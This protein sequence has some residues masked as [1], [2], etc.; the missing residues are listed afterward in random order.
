M[1][2]NIAIQTSHRF[3]QGIKMNEDQ[4]AKVKEVTD[5]INQLKKKNIL[6]IE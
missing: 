4:K 3:D 1:F 6:L 2:E 5:K